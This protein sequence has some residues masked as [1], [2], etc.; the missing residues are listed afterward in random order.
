MRARHFVWSGA[1]GW[2]DDHAMRAHAGRLV[3]F[4]G[5]RAA[6]ATLHEMAG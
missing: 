5:H 6:D 4:G 1:T 2:T 3:H